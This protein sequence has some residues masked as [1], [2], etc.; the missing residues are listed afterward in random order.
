M[1]PG[2]HGFAVVVARLAT[3]VLAVI[4]ADV[5]IRAIVRTLADAM[6]F[7]HVVAGSIIR[8][9][10][11]MVTAA[12]AIAG[13]AT[14]VTTVTTVTAVTT[15]MT[16]AVAT[17]AAATTSA[18]AAATTTAASSSTAPS[19]API[20][21]V[22]ARGAG[23]ITRQDDERQAHNRADHRRQQALL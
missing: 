11:A 13:V 7:T 10:V 21:G 8:P 19:T 2:L 12:A 6:G 9:V 20:L 17:V 18:M 4:V 5:V 16:T 1:G 3:N 23:E 22:G 15:A 14:T